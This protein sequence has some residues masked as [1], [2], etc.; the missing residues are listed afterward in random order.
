MPP[1]MGPESDACQRCAEG[2]SCTGGHGPGL[3]DIW[4]GGR[5]E[6]P[7]GAAPIRRTH[8]WHGSRP[9]SHLGQRCQQKYDTGVPKMHLRQIVSASL[10]PGGII[11]DPATSR[12]PPKIGPSIIYSPTRQSIGSKHRVSAGARPTV[13]GAILRGILETSPKTSSAKP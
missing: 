2:M 5:W 11:P 9:R 10:A 1:R 7:W 3:L 13:L 4:G 12:A 6:A 8:L